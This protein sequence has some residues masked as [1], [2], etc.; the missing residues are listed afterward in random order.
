MSPFDKHQ[1]KIAR[2]TLKLSDIGASCLGGL[3]KPEAILLLKQSGVS[4]KA[5][6]KLLVDAGHTNVEISTLY[7]LA[8]R[9]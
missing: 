9:L 4:L 5:I 8:I 1:Q 3:T 2:Q 7:R 6:T